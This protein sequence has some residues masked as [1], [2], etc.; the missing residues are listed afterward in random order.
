MI[1]R[2]G[3]FFLGVLVFLMPFIGLP[4]FWKT[5]LYMFIGSMLVLS[6]IEFYI[7]KKLS[8]PKLKKEKVQDI[9]IE[10]IPIY[11]R[12]NILDSPIIV[13]TVTPKP[14]KRKV[15]RKSKVSE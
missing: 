15:I 3:T 1:N 2:K 13:E 11:P 5:I 6:S 14:E 9:T 7:P 10:N 8:K 4:T 12:D